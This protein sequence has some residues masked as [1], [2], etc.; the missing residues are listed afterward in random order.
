MIP[1][2]LLYLVEGASAKDET[3]KHEKDP[4]VGDKE[5]LRSIGISVGEVTTAF[6]G[7]TEM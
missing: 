2:R 4:N 3:V 7:G 6:H 1:G 5:W